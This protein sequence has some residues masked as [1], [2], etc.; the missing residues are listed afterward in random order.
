MTPTRVL[1]VFAGFRFPV[2]AGNSVTAVD[3]VSSAGPEGAHNLRLVLGEYID[4]YNAHRSARSRRCSARLGR[5]PA[6]RPGWQ[7]ESF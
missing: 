3:L 7:W 6:S 5:G 4:H 2:S 1:S